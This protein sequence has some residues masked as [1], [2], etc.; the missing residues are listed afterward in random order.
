MTTSNAL[1]IR[2]SAEDVATAKKVL[3]EID[4]P[5]RTYQLTYVIKEGG[6]ERHL[7]LVVTPGERSELK[8]G[9]R[10]PIV[11]GGNTEAKMGHT[12]IQYVDVGLTIRASLTG[13]GNGLRLQSKIEQTSVAGEKSNAAIQ[14]PVIR[15]S[16]LEGQTAL[17]PGT[18]LTLGLMDMPGGRSAEVSVVAE[19]VK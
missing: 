3:A 7:T 16:V 10:V 1:S 17:T 4:A 11:T 12:E 18:Q 2:G 8:Q 19:A 14:D 6:T 5:R 9:S 15:Q 13:L